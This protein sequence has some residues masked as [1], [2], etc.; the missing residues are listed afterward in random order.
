MTSDKTNVTQGKAKKA[1]DKWRNVCFTA[2]HATLTGVLFAE[3]PKDTRYVVWSLE[4]CPETQKLH[5]Q[6]YIEFTTQMRMGAIK[7]LLGDPGVHLEER[8]G[9]ALE[10]ANYCKKLETHVAGPW[11]FGELS[12]QGGR[13]DRDDQISAIG[14]IRA[15]AMSLGEIPDDLLLTRPAAV[16]LALSLAPA[17]RRDRVDVYY[18]EGPPG[19]GKSYAVEDYFPDV[20]KPTLGQDRLWFDGY[21]GQDAIMLDELRGGVKLSFLLQLLDPYKMKVEIKGGTVNACWTKV[22]VC[23]NTP[24]EKWYPK[25]SE[26]DPRTFEALIDRLGF[27][28]GRTSLRDT[29]HWLRLATEDKMEARK[30]LHETFR[31]WFPEKAPAVPRDSNGSP[32]LPLDEEDDD[33]VMLDETI[34]DG[35]VA[36]D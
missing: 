19:C 14:K 32:L 13:L 1:K 21:M 7:K 25:I 22:F 20:F 36:D 4:R 30:E 9:T 11:E 26:N 16:K 12:N 24:P 27:K 28:E 10:A 15:G 17:V 31:S 6:G 29:G 2:H 33:V 35:M 5:W 18:I 34:G 8:K 3:L 23:T